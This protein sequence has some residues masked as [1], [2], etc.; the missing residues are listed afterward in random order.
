MED[1]IINKLCGFC[2]NKKENCME[3]KEGMQKDIFVYKCI[4]YAK[5]ETREKRK[6]DEDNY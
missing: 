2:N 3:Y 6:D 5:K 4:N 1:I